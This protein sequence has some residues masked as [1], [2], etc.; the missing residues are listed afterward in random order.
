MIKSYF[1]ILLMSGVVTQAVAV[2][3]AILDQGN[4]VYTNHCLHCHGTGG[5]GDGHAISALKVK[6]ANLARL[7][8]NGCITKKILGAVLG[9]HKSGYEDSKMPLLKQA[10][11]LEDVYAVSEYIEALQK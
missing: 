8:E 6:P 4:K 10:I 3:Q 11:S 9:K 5:E 2:D 1:L 7:K